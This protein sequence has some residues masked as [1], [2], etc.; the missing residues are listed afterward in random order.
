[1]KLSRWYGQ[2]G[3]RAK[4]LVA[5]MATQTIEAANKAPEKL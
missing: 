5:R 3:D 4:E 2:V 1:M